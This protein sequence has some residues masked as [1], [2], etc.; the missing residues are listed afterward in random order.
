MKV[1]ELVEKFGEHAQIREFLD[2]CRNSGPHYARFEG[3]AGSSVSMS[4]AALFALTD[5]NILVVVPDQEEA[6]FLRS[7][8]VNVLTEHQVLMLTDS[9]KQAFEAEE[10]H[11]DKIQ[12]RAEVVNK[13]QHALHSYIVVATPE[14]IAEKVISTEQLKKNTF[15]LKLGEELDLEFLSDFLDENEFEREDFVYQPG[16]YAVRGGIVDIFSFSNDLPYRI[17]LDGNNIE[18]IRTFEI[19][20]QLS[21]AKI[22][23]LSIVPNIQSDAI[24]GEKVSLFKYFQ[25]ESLMVLRHFE[26]Q[27]QYLIKQWE[28]LK[29]EGKHPE[30][31]WLSP[32]EIK[33]LVSEYPHIVEFGAMNAFRTHQVYKFNTEP[34]PLFQKNIEMLLN[35]L[36]GNEINNIMNLVFSDTGKQIERLIAIIQDRQKEINVVP[37]YHGLAE[38]FLDRDLKMACYTEHQLFERYYR[39][40]T[41]KRGF[42]KSTALTLKE[43]SELQPGDF[44]THIDHG[45]GKFLGLQKTLV[46]G[47]VQEAVK[48][49]YRDGDLLYVNVNSLHKI[50]KFTGKDGSEPALH[51]LGSG[52]WEKQKAS[53]KKKVKDIARE[54]IGLYAKRKAQPGFAF[55][56]D[57][58]MQIELEASFLY[59]DTPDQAKATDEIKK[60]MENEKPMDRLLCGDVGFGK[61]EVAIRTA[62]K[63]VA[64]SKQVAVLVPT[65]ILAH[66]HY[67]TFKERLKGLPVNVDY[68]N[69]F[70]STG[71]QKKTLKNLQEGKVDILIGTHRIVGKDVKFKDLGLLIIDE[72]QKFGVGVKDKLKEIRVNVDTLTLTA[73]P[74]PRTLHFSLMG[75]RDLS[76]INTPPPNRFPIKTEL[77]TF[78]K[79]IIHKA[80]THELSRGGQTYFVHHRVKDIYDFQNM[81]ELM[82]PGIRVLVAH[83]QMEGHDLEDVMVRFIEGDADVL[84]ATTIIEAGL[85]I[86]NCNTIIINNAHMFGLSDLHQMRGRVGRSNRKAYCYLL[87][88]PLNSLT[89]DAKKR[90]STIEEYSDLGGGFHVA[91]RD[92]DIRGAGNLLGGE[93]SGFISEIGFDTYHK[94]LDEAI[95]EL[96]HDEFADLFADFKEDVSSKDCQVD[97]DLDMLIPDS[98]VRNMPER[99]SLYTELGRVE[100][101]EMLEAFTEKLID[102]FGRFPKEVSVLLSSV[103]LKWMGKKMGFEKISLEKNLMK[104]YFPSNEKAAL[105]DSPAFM[106][107]MHHVA[108]NPMKYDLKQS[109][110]TVILIVK[111]VDNMNKATEILE[112]LNNF[113]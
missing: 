55:S 5:K 41:H 75:A 39:Y 111:S 78:N 21:V 16:Q 29:D 32:L 3:L 102:R 60:D 31:T 44:V 76:V 19:D 51:K 65:T 23:H 82:V 66:Q 8:L 69:R 13:L 36:Q 18:S 47:V 80:V 49:S 52:V 34:Q 48:I 74:I 10:A 71:E 87:S 25:S 22:A 90:L 57:S 94:I 112:E 28:Q 73:T 93:Q 45:V 91:M 64:D 56:P 86:P 110:K 43:L 6:E 95:R 35:H 12:S 81:L 42:T 50:S 109:S 108:S 72:E 106:K 61:T 103:R 58:Y 96:K 53:T 67:R 38:G 92:L 70:K 89:S 100:N 88:P 97:T 98:Y 59:E 104:V 84:I 40:K 62:F 15:E 2:N 79:E 20:T 63:A 54:L 26:D 107:I 4:I 27:Y 46:N 11:P 1:K 83:G 113:Y 17:E 77:H 33:N 30:Y 105:F 37:V 99:L 85:D 101:E 24:A 68:I 9:F 7:D 14:A